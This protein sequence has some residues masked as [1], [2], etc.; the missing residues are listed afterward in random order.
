MEIIK[1][2]DAEQ[3]KVKT[4]LAPLYDKWVADMKAK[5]LPGDEV[6]KYFREAIK[7]VPAA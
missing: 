3:A 6:L 7:R 2:S 4:T 5:N 1:L